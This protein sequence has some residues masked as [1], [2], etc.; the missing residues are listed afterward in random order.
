MS[1][2][3]ITS[4]RNAFERP[5]VA[6]RSGG[7]VD[8]SSWFSQVDAMPCALGYDER[9]T[10]AHVHGSVSGRQLEPDGDRSG[11]QEQELVTVGV[12]LARVGR[13]A[14][15]HRRP[16]REAIDPL[17]RTAVLLLDEPGSAIGAVD[18][19][20]LAG[21]VDLLARFDLVGGAHDISC[22]GLC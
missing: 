3:S 14:G 22:R 8:E 16:D 21:Q 17:R 15:E 13:V 2:A 7:D 6:V 10:W 1:A 9:F 19:H 4:W 20:D 5:V 11:D 12:H 18:A